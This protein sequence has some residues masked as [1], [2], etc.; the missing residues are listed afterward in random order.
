M[1]IVS[2]ALAVVAVSAQ[3]GAQP[4]KS[5]P[6]AQ[7]RVQEKSLRRELLEMEKA[8]QAARTAMFKT[9][10]EKGISLTSDKPITDPDAVAVI[11]EE[12]QRLAKVDGVHLTRLKA[13]IEKHGW[14]GKTLVGEDGAQAAWMLAQHADTKFQEKCLK[15]MEAAPAGE[16]AST[17]LAYLTDR[18]LVSQKKAQKYGTQLGA[19]MVPLLIEDEKQVDQR[20]GALGLPPMAEY[21]KSTKAEYDKL[22]GKSSDKK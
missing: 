10:G 22:L 21:L 20:R 8:D 18:V 15:L 2:L 11:T 3:L 4:P 13:I 19:D 5:T 16:V 7:T 17:D 1:R 6:G 12:T 14:P 9:L